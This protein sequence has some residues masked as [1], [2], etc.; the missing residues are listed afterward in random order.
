[1]ATVSLVLTVLGDD[2]P[3]LVESVSE[4]IAVYG[5]NWVESRMARLAGKFAG[6][7]RATVPAAN[8]AA[9]RQ[10]LQALERHGLTVVIETS[11]S[12][13]AVQDYRGLR[14]D[15]VGNDHAGIVHDI[16]HAL[17]QRGINIDVFESE[18]TS[19][20]MSGGMLFK[21]T[22]HLRVPTRV[23]LSELKETLEKL[24][25]DLIVDITLEDMSSPRDTPG[26]RV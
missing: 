2:R 13:A 21:A 26:R 10:A 16:S 4:S 6:I 18:C 7:L 20:P 5:G 11:T 22:A 23:M 15:V 3:G 17:A 8:A 24:A 14:L 19:A 12:D 1:M 9:L 25:H